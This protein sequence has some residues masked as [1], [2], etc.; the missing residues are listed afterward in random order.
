M[1]LAFGIYSQNCII[2]GPAQYG[3]RLGESIGVE[4]ANACAQF[5]S[6]NAHELASMTSTLV[7]SKA[8]RSGRFLY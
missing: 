2:P 4:D 1:N 8:A 6:K 3:H 7:I 5:L